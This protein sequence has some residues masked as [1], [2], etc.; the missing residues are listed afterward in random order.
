MAIALAKQGHNPELR[1]EKISFEV[2]GVVQYVKSGVKDLIHSWLMF[3]FVQKACL[4]MH[5]SYITSKLL[6]P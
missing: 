4:Q 2:D 6:H 3:L 5:D 1:P